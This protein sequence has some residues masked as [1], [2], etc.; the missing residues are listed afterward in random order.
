MRRFDYP[1]LGER[2]FRK[3]LDNGLEVVVV[4]KPSHAKR[5]AFFATRYGGMD[6]R[7]RLDGRWQDTPAGIAHYLEH[8]MFDT[9]EGNGRRLKLWKWRHTF[10]RIRF[11]RRP[12]KRYCVRMDE[13][14]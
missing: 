7:F 14:R 6:L 9:Q 1:R 13:A 2:V 4:S 3:K 5:Y 11:W 8:K 10:R 12:F